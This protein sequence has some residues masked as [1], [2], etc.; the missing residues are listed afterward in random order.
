MLLSYYYFILQILPSISLLR[1][2]WLSYSCLL[3]MFC[4]PPPT[5]QWTNRETIRAW[6][7]IPCIVASI[8]YVQTYAYWYYIRALHFSLHWDSMRRHV[9]VILNLW[10]HEHANGGTV[11]HVQHVDKTDLSMIVLALAS[12]VIEMTGVRALFGAFFTRILGCISFFLGI[13]FEA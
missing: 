7:L 3:S 8:Y 2:C 10:I 13:Q 6:A 1:T 12:D 9:A 4:L 11:G 5:L